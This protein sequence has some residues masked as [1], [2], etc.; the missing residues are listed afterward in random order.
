M[1]PSLAASRLV[2]CVSR[3][4]LKQHRSYLVQASTRHVQ[5]HQFLSSSWRVPSM[6]E[7]HRKEIRIFFYRQLGQCSPKINMWGIFRF[8]R[9][10]GSMNLNECTVRTAAHSGCVH[11]LDGAYFRFGKAGKDSMAYRELNWRPHGYKSAGTTS[12]LY[13]LPIYYHRRKLFTK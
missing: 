12:R 9:I 5:E 1:W 3:T 7:K 10:D 13:A 6:R 11:C 8:F 2:K 4:I